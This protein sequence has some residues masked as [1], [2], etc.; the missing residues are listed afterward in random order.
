MVAR[1]V[2][3]YLGWRGRLSRRTFW[4]SATL[5]WLLFW[6]VRAAM[7]PAL[8]A[9]STLLLSPA[10]LWML[11]MLAVKRYHD[12]DRAGGRLLLLLIPI[13]GP[14]WVAG[15]LTLRRGSEG[16]NGYG[17]DP[18]GSDLDYQTVPIPS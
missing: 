15:E 2:D 5:V 11:T 1:N 10:L 13:L 17:A 8:A 18:R 3:R 6:A 9:T 16:A 14:L 12:Q 7:G 4:C